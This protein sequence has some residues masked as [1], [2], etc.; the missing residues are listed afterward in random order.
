MGRQFIQR[1]QWVQTG[2]PAT[3]DDSVEYAPGQRGGYLPDSDRLWQ[4]VKVDSGVTASTPTGVSAAAQ[5]AFWKDNNSYLVTNDN[6]FANGGVGD[7]RNFVAGVFMGAITGGN[8]GFIIKEGK[9]INVKTTTSPTA[10]DVLVANTGTAA[11][12]TSVAAGTAPTCKVIG[13]ATGPKSGAN[14]PTDVSIGTDV[15]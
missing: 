4:Y 12:A 7:A 14:V 13:V 6:R 3:V 2:N 5:V 9:D 8:S 11:D 15:M 1:A 10:G